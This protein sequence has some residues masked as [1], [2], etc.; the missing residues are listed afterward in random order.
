MNKSTQ[1]RSRRLAAE[2]RRIERR[3]KNAVAPNFSGPLLGEA[4]ITY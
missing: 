3:L 1:R 4:N 2:A